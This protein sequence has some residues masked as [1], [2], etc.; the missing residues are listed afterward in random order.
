MPTMWQDLFIFLFLFLF[1]FSR[2]RF[3]TKLRNFK[4]ALVHN[5]ER[6]TSNWHL[7][8]GLSLHESVFDVPR[9]RPFVILNIITWWSICMPVETPPNV[10][11]NS[12]NLNI[13]HLRFCKNNSKSDE[14]M[15]H[16]FVVQNQNGQHCLQVLSVNGAKLWKEAAKW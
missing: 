3:E 4:M 14:D 9:G 16:L 1:L 6:S 12:G 10:K 5:S 15:Q 8:E 11:Q 2:G 7:I 13:M